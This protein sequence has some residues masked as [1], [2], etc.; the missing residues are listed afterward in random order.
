MTPSVTAR[1]VP[2]AGRTTAAPLARSA[3]PAVRKRSLA[4]RSRSARDVRIKVARKDAR[5]LR[6]A[7]RAARLP[8]RI[9]RK[10]RWRTTR[11][12]LTLVVK[13]ARTSANDHD[14]SIWIGRIPEPLDRKGVR[15]LLG[16]L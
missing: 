5:K 15:I 14:R 13:R 6:R 12:S 8:E 2:V 16:Q 1:A 9:Q 3:L 7:V 11:R 10:V 4:A